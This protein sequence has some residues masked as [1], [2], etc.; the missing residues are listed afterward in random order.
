MKGLLTRGFTPL[1]LARERTKV[2]GSKLH[3]AYEIEPSSPGF[4]AE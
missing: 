1:F 2:R 4:A 3:V